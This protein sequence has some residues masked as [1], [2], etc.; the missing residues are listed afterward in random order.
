MSF[1]FPKP[2]TPTPTTQQPPAIVPVTPPAGQET[3]GA[4]ATKKRGAPT[5]T[6]FGGL[7]NQ[8]AQT[9]RKTLLGQ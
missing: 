1:F 4:K 5:Q 3:T 6:R 8:Q 7:L 2:S 9:A